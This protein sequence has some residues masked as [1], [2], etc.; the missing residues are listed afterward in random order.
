M[1]PAAFHCKYIIITLL[2]STSE[3]LSWQYPSEKDRSRRHLRSIARLC[4]VLAERLERGRW[5]PSVRSH[6]HELPRC[7]DLW[8][9]AERQTAWLRVDGHLYQNTCLIWRMAILA[10]Q[11]NW[12]LGMRQRRLGTILRHAAASRR[13]RRTIPDEIP[14]DTRRTLPSLFPY[15]PC[16]DFLQNFQLGRGRYRGCPFCHCIVLWGTC[17]YK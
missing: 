3:V 6:Q 4:N 14:G 15:V 7:F 2:P 17:R 16:I 9:P 8:Q 1:R 11:T 12:T 13:K 5:K 10:L